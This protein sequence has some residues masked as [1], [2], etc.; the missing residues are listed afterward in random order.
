MALLL[1]PHFLY[2]SALTRVVFLAPAGVADRLLP[3]TTTGQFSTRSEPFFFCE[4]I[5][6][7]FHAD[8]NSFRWPRLHSRRGVG[9]LDPDG[10]MVLRK[11]F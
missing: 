1:L 7:V 5:D 9:N 6:G 11:D 8:E 2:G 4:G 3:P 10:S